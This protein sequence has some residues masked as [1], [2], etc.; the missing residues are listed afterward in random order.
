MTE[1]TH[2]HGRDF[3]HD[4]RRAAA[5]DAPRRPRP[6]DRRHRPADDRRRPRRP[7]PAV[8]G[9]HRVSARR[10]DLDAAV[11]PRLRPLRPQAAVPGG[12]RRLPRRLGAQRRRAVARRADRLPRAAGPRRGRADDARDGDRRRARARRASAAATRATSRWCSCVAS[13]AGPLL[14]GVFVDQLSWRWVFYVN[15]PIGALALAVISATLHL[16]APERPGADRLPGR[17]AARRARS[18]ACCSS[19]PGAGASTRGARPRS[20]AWPPGPWRC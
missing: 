14:G 10:D 8:L 6:D 11:G 15:L 19:P 9:R 17:R 20:S 1:T 12:D 18:R 4:V 5:R 13:V 16:P 2:T 7:R 3:A